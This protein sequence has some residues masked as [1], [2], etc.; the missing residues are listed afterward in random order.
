[1]VAVGRGEIGKLV[2]AAKHHAAHL[3]IRI[4][5]GKIPMARRGASE[6]GYLAFHPQQ[7]QLRFQRARA[8]RLSSLTVSTG[9]SAAP[10]ESSIQSMARRIAVDARHGSCTA[11]KFLAKNL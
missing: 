2:A 8:M 6:V 10:R 5:Q 4:L 1:V 7:R 9:N 3:G 11:D